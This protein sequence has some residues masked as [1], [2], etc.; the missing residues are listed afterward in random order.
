M[1]LVGFTSVM[2][3]VE[4]LK[5]PDPML[6]KALY[7]LIL[8]HRTCANIVPLESLYLYPNLHPDAPPSP[9]PN[10]HQHVSES[11]DTPRRNFRNAISTALSIFT[12]RDTS[13]SATVPPPLSLGKPFLVSTPRGANTPTQSFPDLQRMTLYNRRLRDIVGDQRRAPPPSSSCKRDSTSRRPPLPSSSSTASDCV[14]N[15]GHATACASS[16]CPYSCAMTLSATLPISSSCPPT[17]SNLVVGTTATQARS[18]L[19][20]LAITRSASSG[21][22]V[23]NPIIANTYS[24]LTTQN[25]CT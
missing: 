17:P 4:A 18:V 12:R 8:Q 1:S 21:A 14:Y 3:L 16:Q 9:T 7:R 15:G 2:E 23:A 19:Y 11:L 10:T 6:E 25:K 5:S 24:T 22:L 20:S 13:A